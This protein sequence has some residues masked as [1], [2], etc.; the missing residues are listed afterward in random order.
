MT[1]QTTEALTARL[2]A[3]EAENAYLKSLLAENGIS[4]ASDPPGKAE[5]AAHPIYDPDQGARIRPLDVSRNLAR[6]FFAY[7]W[8]RTDVY[9]KRFQN[10]KTGKVG[11][12]PQ[13]DHFWRAGICPK[14]AG[15]KVKC[16]ECKSRS[17]KEL[18]AAQIEG[19][20]QGNKEDGS[21]VIGIFPLFQ[22]GSC[23]LLVFDFDDHSQGA[24]EREFANEKEK[25]REEADALAGI[26]RLNG[27]PMLLERSR[28]GLGA[29]LW[30]FFEQAIDA[31]LARRLGFS[32]LEKGAESVNLK[33]FQTYDRMLPAQDLLVENQLGSVIALPLQGQA[34]KA[35]NSAFVDENWNA[36]PDQ[37]GALFSTPK[38]PTSRVEELI[39]QWSADRPSKNTL[40]AL[41][42]LEGDRPWERGAFFHAEDVSG[43]LHIV[44]SNQ[45]YMETQN[46]TPRI[47]NQMRRLAAF[48]NP[49]FFKNTALGLS[50]FAHS[51]YI[52]LGEDDGGYL[53]LPRGL[54]DELLTK[55]DDA[56]I[57]YEIIDKRSAQNTVKAEFVGTLR[58]QQAKAVDRLL[59]YENGI[60]FAATAFGKTVVCSNLIAQ[61]KVSTLILLESS[62]LIEQWQNA[63]EQFLNVEEALPTY[64]TRSGRIKT[65]SSVIGVI[66]GPKDTSTGIIDLAMAGSLCKKGVFHPRIKEYGMVLVD[67]CHHSASETMRKILR[68]VT[69]KY[70]YG[71]T[72][73]PFRGDGLD[74]INFMLLGPIRFEYTAREKAAEQG[75]EHILLPRFTRTVLAQ[76]RESIPIS[77]AYET[78]QTSGTRNEQI[79]ADIK[80]CVEACRTPVVLTKQV[81]HAELLYQKVK[82]SADKVFLLTG[83]QSKNENALLRAQM[84]AVRQTESMILVATGQLIGEG[85][86]YPRLDTLILAAPVSWK[87]VVEQ[88]AGRLNRDY[89]A[90]RAVMIYDY[91]DVHIPVFDKM[92]AKRLR[93][94]KRIG[95]R[96][97][98][99]AKGEMQERNAIYDSDH[100]L[101]IYEQDLT[102][103]VDEIVISSPT[104]GKSKVQRLLELLK[105]R[106]QAGVKVTV[107]TWHPDAYRYGREEHRLAL[108]E[109]LRRA[110][111]HLELA[112]EHC[113]H[114]AVIDKKVV[115]YGSMNLL[116]KDDVEDNIM[117]IISDQI[118]EELLELTFHKDSGLTAYGQLV[119]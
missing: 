50:N 69:A 57:D 46:L 47:Q 60:L 9:S 76:G 55:C 13:C 21:D 44:L 73:T 75:I 34:L 7:F 100:Y 97:C 90:K 26:C 83:R 109:T 45:I 119:F 99:G 29:H 71:V 93:T 102:Q 84:A 112:K 81:E 12:Y 22:D 61:R 58:E 6:R 4:Y 111:V 56:K 53:C 85:F 18:G 17:W 32:L 118:A 52:Y 89:A 68:E 1:P 113:E 80:S 86:D 98:S 72:A 42:P 62:P 49:I 88:Y 91:V 15:M 48:L 78:I 28:S 79:A 115:W 105:E 40:D 66:Q 77:A 33:T 95:Y 74:K 117:R 114:Y 37:I 94:Y 24:D 110:G 63:L 11:Y 92:Y 87:G 25:W 70:I 16:G 3:L 41:V 51:R 27:V 19:H 96:L 116:S 36:Y 31:Q 23:R 20:L 65:R 14:V 30:I 38:M 108:M 64:Q 104:L 10:K 101:P 8:G 103:A 35:G 2:A 54:L 107:V 82:N 43:R 106:Q 5:Q 67:E 39:R 59:H